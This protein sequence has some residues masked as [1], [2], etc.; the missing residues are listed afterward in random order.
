MVAC[1][2]LVFIA[3]SLPRLA[4]AEPSFF[5]YE[6]VELNKNY[7]TTT[8]RFS[9]ILSYRAALEGHAN[10][11]HCLAAAVNTVLCALFAQVGEIIYFILETIN[12]TMYVTGRK[13]RHRRKTERVSCGKY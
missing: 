12:I 5:R 4:R 1:L 9:N 3:V 7:S 13:K 8:N 2:L 10:N 6:F 11:A